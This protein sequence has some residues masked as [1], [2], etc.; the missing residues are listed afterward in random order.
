[1]GGASVWRVA[2]GE[3]PTEYATGFTN[4]MGLGFAPDGTLYV[5][6]LVHE[7]LMGVFA[8]GQPPIGAVM[9]VAPGGGEPTLV[10]TGEQLMALGGLDVD[11]DGS[12]YVSTGTIL[13]EGAGTVVKITP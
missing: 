2:D 11:A 4:I 1:M 12:V 13:G 7:G 8:G 10:A 5:A 9:S 3:D 6:E